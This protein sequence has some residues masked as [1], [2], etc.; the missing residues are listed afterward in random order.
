[1]KIFIKNFSYSNSMKNMEKE[2]LKI[3]KSLEI[4]SLDTTSYSFKELILR[5]FCNLLD[6]FN[7]LKIQSNNLKK[8]KEKI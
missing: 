7:C 6:Y 3:Q 5:D 4:C 2:F 8:F 1:M